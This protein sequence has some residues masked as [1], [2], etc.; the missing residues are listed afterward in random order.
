M[1]AAM[2]TNGWKRE[3]ARGARLPAGYAVAWMDRS[4]CLLV[5]YPW[6][7]NWA[8]RQ[9]RE[10]AWRLARAMRVFGGIGPDEQESVDA[11]EFHRERQ[12]LAEH[13]VTGYLAGWQECYDTC[14]EAIEEEL[15]RAGVG[16]I[17]EFPTAVRIQASP[18]P[19]RIK[20]N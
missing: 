2:K 9:W 18:K 4:R 10:F 11:L 14:L 12:A 19:P 6:P 7:V 15:G 5:C 20:P 8:A 17:E 13:Y 16:E 3:V 1:R